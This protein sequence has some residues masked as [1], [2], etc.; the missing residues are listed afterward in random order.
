MLR[1]RED[2]E[3]APEHQ[4]ET[5]LCVL[6]RKLRDRRL[7][8]DEELQF[9]DKVDHELPVRAQRLAQRVAPAGQLGVALAQ[10]RA[11]Q[12]LKGLRQRGIRDVA[13][14]LI[15]LAGGEQAARRHQRLVQLVDDRGLADAGIAGDEH[16][17]RS[18][19]G[20]DAV[21][22]GEQGVDLALSPVQ[23]LG[24]QQPVRRV[25]FAQREGVDPV[26][27]LPFSKAAPE[28]APRRRPRSGSAPR[29][30]WRAASSR[31]R[32]RL[33]DVL[34]PLVRAAPAVSRYGSGPTPSDRR[35]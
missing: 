20:D 1:P 27:S 22:G 18:A 10:E 33:R 29:R 25:M 24:D 30:S 17:L 32:R 15:E 9:G 16:Q 31:W 23:F 11:D 34:H 21:E 13:L 35:R 26:L 6:R 4:L 28:V 8:S 2:A 3:K 12:A 5:A 19:A 7:L 14:V